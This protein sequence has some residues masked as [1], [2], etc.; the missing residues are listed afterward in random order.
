MKFIYLYVIVFFGGAAV[1]AIEILGTRFLGPF[2]GVSL[3]L[4]SALISVTLAAL[5][6]GYALGGRW[7][8]RGPKYSRLS[9]VM[10]VSGIWLL[11]LP[12]LRSPV[13]RMAEP[14]GLRWAVLVTAFILF[15]IPLV[16][17]G[18]VSPYAI[19]LRAS[20]LEEVGRT[21]GDL[22][23]V[24][25]VASVLSALV[26]GFILIPNVGVTRLTLMIG[27]VLLLGASIALMAARESRRSR[28]L[29]VL[30]LVTGAII[31][32]RIPGETADP[33][34]GLVAVEQSAY[35]DIRVIDWDED[36]YLLIDGGGHTVIEKDSWRSLFRYAVVMDIAK[37]LYRRPG[38]LLLIGLGGGSIVK[39]FHQDGWDIDVVEID[40]VIT[41]VA[42]DYF[43][44]QDSECRVF[45]MDGRQYLITHE[46]QY[47]LILMDAFGSSSIPF[48]LVTDESFGLAKSRLKPGGMLAL[49]IESV[50]WKDVIVQSVG[51]TLKEHFQNVLVLP[52]S[53]PPNV[54]GNQIIMAS[55]NKID[56][57]ED[58]LGRPF[59]FLS[60]AYKH[61]V[62]MQ[63]NHAWN[64]R[65]EPGADDAPI[66]T[67]D[68][69]PVDVWSER[70][71]L[72]A[73]KILHREFAWKDLI[74]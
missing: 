9:L 30:T 45:H 14:L 50:G 21:A 18:M 63:R 28:T 71:N 6:V 69:N 38:D 47:D 60:D 35:A 7:A 52:T 19:R 59:D 15:F 37:Y 66:L 70:I 64:N 12:W 29:T 23:A 34:Q 73:R 2:Y 67:D 11:I 25:T 55:D 61:W 5:S 40:P 32:W 39:S 58:W 17:L 22:Y 54:L 56:F 20:R 68:L 41:K 62:V 24:S 43:G 51:V 44:L 74:W 10:A 1:L 72:E 49:N 26:T 3:F 57:N 53:E 16:L 4:W 65:F 27:I 48:H 8:D 33:H 46:E 31:L 13:L 36:R 42:K